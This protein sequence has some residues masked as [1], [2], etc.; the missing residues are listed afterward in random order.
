M[1][2]FAEVDC[3]VEIKE[4]R[5]AVKCALLGQWNRF[6][7]IAFKGTVMSLKRDNLTPVL[8]A[9]PKTSCS[10]GDQPAFIVTHQ[11]G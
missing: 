9:N 10:Q 5:R 4:R 1:P 7:Y 6:F 8:G 11:V 2:V 3:L